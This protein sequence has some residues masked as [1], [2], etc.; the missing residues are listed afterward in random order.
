MPP[1]VCLI[2]SAG[3]T[4]GAGGVLAV[5]AHHRRGLGGGGAVDALEMDQRLAA[6]G[7]ALHA[8]LHAR[9]AADAAALVDDEHRRVVDAVA[10]SPSCWPRRA[11]RGRGRRWSVRGRR[12]A[13]T[14]TAATL[15]SG[16]F[17]IGSTARLVSW[18]AA[19]PP[20]QWYGMN[21]VSGRIVVT[22]FAGSVIVPRRDVTVTRSPSATPRLVGELW[23]HLAQRLGVLVDERGDATGLGAGQVLAHDP[24]GGEPHRVVVVDD[25]GRLAGTAPRGTGPCRRDGRTCRPRTGGA[26]PGV[27]PRGSARTARARPRSAP[28]S[29]P[30][31]RRCRRPTRSRSSSKISC[32]VVVRG[33]AR[34]G[35]AARRCRGGS[36][37][38]VGPRPVVRPRR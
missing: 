20:G 32:G 3:Q 13:A 35:R 26:C 21:T 8:G 18:F 24:A 29:R 11:D 4:C 33:S 25:L 12:L 7:A 37:S 15:N 6:V 10:A 5:H 19:L 36:A 16:I 1:S 31:S 34:P 28:T 38:R 17:E 27:P 14:R 9:F 22:T 23:V 2:A 30:G